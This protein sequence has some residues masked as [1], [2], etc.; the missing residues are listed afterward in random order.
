[1][2]SNIK[3]QRICQHCGNEFLAR[4]TL[5]RYCSH[6]CNSRDYKTRKRAEKIKISTKEIRYLKQVTFEELKAKEFLTVRQ[7]AALISCSRQNVYKLINTGKLKAT[8]ILKKKT[9]VRRV[10]LD[11]LFEQP[12]KFSNEKETEILPYDISNCYSVTEV[13]NKYGISDAT[14]RQLI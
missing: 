12:K 10:D 14:V 5:T 8:N 3:V 4:T 11:E 1:M 9:L 13:Q 2:S 7:V 6:K